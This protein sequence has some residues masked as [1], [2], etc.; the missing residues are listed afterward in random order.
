MRV[1]TATRQCGIGHRRRLGTLGLTFST[2]R[3]CFF[4][5]ADSS[6]FDFFTAKGFGFFCGASRAAVAEESRSKNYWELVGI[7]K[8]C[9]ELL[10]TNMNYY[11][12]IRIIKNF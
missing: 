4:F 5:I 2:G 12:L 1:G 11:E 8:K 9:K 7:V 6:F 10:S 3:G